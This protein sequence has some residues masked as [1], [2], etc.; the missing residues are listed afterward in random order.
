MCLQ[1]AVVVDRTLLPLMDKDTHMQSHLHT[2]ESVRSTLPSVGGEGLVVCSWSEFM[3][4][5]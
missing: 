4:Q 3:S 5:L 2:L 1:E